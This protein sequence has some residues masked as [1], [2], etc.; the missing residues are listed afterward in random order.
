MHGIDLAAKLHLSRLHL[1][2]E[3]EVALWDQWR[4]EFLGGEVIAQA[5]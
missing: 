1:K 2:A 5:N 4:S 3:S